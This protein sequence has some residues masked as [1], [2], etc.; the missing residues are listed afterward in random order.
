MLLGKKITVVMPAFNAEFT[1]RRTCEEIPRDIVDDIILVDDASQDQTVSVAKELGLHHVVHSENR[2]YGSNQ[3]TCY[4]EA[5]HRGADIVIM[6]HPDYQY[7]PKLIPAM[8]G[9]IASGIYDAVTASRILGKGAIKGGM[10]RYKYWS[11]R[12]LTLF[13]NGLMGQKLSEY[14]SGYRAFSRKVLS[15]L[16]LGTNSDD[17]IFDNQMLAQVAYFGFRM[18]EISCPTHYSKDSSSINFLR[19]VRYGLGVL[20]VSIQ[21]RLAKLGLSKAPIFL[22]Q[23]TTLNSSPDVSTE[24]QD[25]HNS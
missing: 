22:D 23:K 1:L 4:G 12:F 15:K 9:M 13:Q 21:Y 20:K 6:I 11:N 10:P 5:L 14:H 24:L 17:F 7:T 3:K 16:P 19:S 25:V 18:G 2:G 8:A